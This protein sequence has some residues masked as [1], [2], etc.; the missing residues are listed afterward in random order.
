[1]FPEFHNKQ[2]NGH[3]NVKLLKMPSIIP[4]N[5]VVYVIRVEDEECIESKVEWETEFSAY[6]VCY[7]CKISF[8]LYEE[9]LW[10]TASH[11]GQI[12]LY[13]QVSNRPLH[14]GC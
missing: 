9:F 14:V 13:Y 3:I 4:S 10:K 5:I 6:K 2:L 12:E 7:Y 11:I 1:M 8:K